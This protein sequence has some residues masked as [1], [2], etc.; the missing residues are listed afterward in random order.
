MSQHRIHCYC[1]IAALVTCAGLGLSPAADKLVPE[2]VRTLEARCGIPFQDNAVLQQ[3]IPLPVWGASLPGARVTVRF[4]TQ[5]RTAVADREGKWRVV[6]DPMDAVRLKSVNDC[7]AGRAMTIVCEKDG[8]KA[9]RE[10][11]NLVV[12]EVWLCAGQSNMAGKM[13]RAGSPKHFPPDSILK[14]K[15]PALRQMVS[16]KPEWLVCTP[17]TAVWFKKVCFF[18][19]RRVQLDILVPVGIINAAV[20]GSKIEPWISREPYGPGNHYNE[21]IAPLVGYGLRGVVWY[22]GESNARDGREHLPKLRSLILG[23]RD[24]WKQGDPS[25]GSG[26]AF[27]VYFVQLPGIGTSPA[28]NPAMGDGR[29]EI[30]QAYFEALAIR[31]TGMAVTIDIGDVREHPPNKY[32]TGV[33]LARLALRNDYGFKDVATCPLYE[34]HKIE[35]DT[36]RISFANAQNGL[37]IAVKEGFLPP[38]AAPDTKLGWLAIQDKDGTWHWAEGRIDGSELIVSCKDVREPVAVRYAYTNHPTGSLLYSKDGLPVSP[39][40]TN[41]YGDERATDDH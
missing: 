33:R 29:A 35:D 6:L 32:D 5:T 13:G 26:Q 27:P 37:M 40:S 15:Y 31:N 2:A 28:D 23:W 14:A 36:V 25:T 4:D 7:P 8:E 16:P 3:K 24:A 38:K 30:R 39:F 17:E 20:G 1:L 9:V 41:G 21:R 34:N 10:I 18:F 11:A 19:A 12:G 22:Q